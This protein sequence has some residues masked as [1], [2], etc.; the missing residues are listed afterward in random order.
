MYGRLRMRKLPFLNKASEERLKVSA[1][2]G[3][4]N[5]LYLEGSICGIPCLMLVD[6][7]A[8]VTLART[9]LAQ[10]LKGNFIYT[11]PNISLKISAGEKAEI[12]GKLDAAIE[13]RSRKFEN[14][15]YAADITDTCTLGLE[16]LQNLTSRR[17]G[18]ERYT[19]RRR[20]NSFVFSQSRAFKV[21][22]C[23]GQRENYYTSK[24]GMS[25]PGCSRSVWKTLIAKFPRKVSLWRHTRLFKKRS[26]PHSSSKSGQ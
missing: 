18:E 26:H 9:D 4:R 20:G 8:N 17:P 16:F 11:A 1:L 12:H 15:I 19:N 5:G 24:I 23:I 14:R 21:M 6:T 22:L 25:Y 13:C 10:K 2:C 3:G 7:G